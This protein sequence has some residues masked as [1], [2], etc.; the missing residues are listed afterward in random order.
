MHS[1]LNGWSGGRQVDGSISALDALDMVMQSPKVREAQSTGE[2]TVLFDSGIRTGSDI[3]KAIALGAQAVLS[4][5][6]VSPHTFFL[7]PSSH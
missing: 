1:R 5:S 3:L 7:D 4:T 2:F 6:H